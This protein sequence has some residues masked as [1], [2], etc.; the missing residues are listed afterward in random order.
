MLFSCSLKV[1]YFVE[2][3]GIEGD[4]VRQAYSKRWNVKVQLTRSNPFAWACQNMHCAWIVTI[5]H[6]SFIVKYGDACWR[7]KVK[8]FDYCM[9]HSVKHCITQPF[10]QVFCDLLTYCQIVYRVC[11]EMVKLLN[12]V[13][14]PIKSSSQ[15]F[16]ICNSITV[17]CKLSLVSLPVAQSVTPNISSSEK[18]WL[19]LRMADLNNNNNNKWIQTSRP[20]LNMLN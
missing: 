7:V 6:V 5:T 12:M 8:R 15:V 20:I 17:F 18:L 2:D 13:T 9:I 1:S 10:H 4:T 14:G 16:A 19:S 11:K 3:M